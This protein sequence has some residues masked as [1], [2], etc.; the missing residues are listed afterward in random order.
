LIARVGSFGLTAV[1]AVAVTGAAGCAARQ[2]RFAQGF[3][4]PGTPSVK[5]EG[6]AARP[7]ED[8]VR[9]YVRKVGELQAK[10]RPTSSLLPTLESTDPVLSKALLLLAMD[11]TA[12]RHIAVAEAYRSAGVTDYAFR[13]YLRAAALQRC[14]AVAYEGMA[15]L[16]RD[17]ARPDIALGDAY[18]GLYCNPR[19]SEIY[20]T[21]GTIMAALGENGNAE[22]AYRRSL[23]LDPLS[24]PALTNLGYLELQSGH[25]DEAVRLCAQA[26]KVAPDFERARNNLAL[27]HLSRGDYAAAQQVLADGRGAIAA[28][29]LGVVRLATGEF[30]RAAEAFD[31]AA[32]LQ[33]SMKIARLRA[34]Q[35]RTAAATGESN[36]NDDRR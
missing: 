30:R 36:G 34:L 26:V 2:S 35:A 19:S 6:P 17:W 23:A 22:R 1:L 18:R 13:H 5:I 11:D 24:A 32:A 16:W 12:D 9:D 31:A 8:T 10:A 21:I 29:N 4:K 27:A 3:I 25:S 14:N 20:N 15:R 33:P 28:Y 7:V